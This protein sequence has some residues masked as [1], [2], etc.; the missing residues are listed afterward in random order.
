[1]HF[2]TALAAV[3]AGLLIVSGAAAQ[4]TPEAS[5]LQ[6]FA[7]DDNARL[8]GFSPNGE[9]VVGQ[10]EDFELCTY[11][12]PS[13]A[14]I[15]CADLE[16]Q[17][18]ELDRDSIAWAPDSSAFAFASPAFTY[19]IDSDLWR[20]DAETGDLTNLTDD[21]YDGVMPILETNGVDTRIDVDIAPA[22]SPDGEV[23]AFSRTVIEP[24]EEDT[25]SEVWTLD[26]ATGD[27]ARLA[28]FDDTEPGIVWNR[29]LWS[30]DG[31]TIYASIRHADSDNPENGIHAID[32]ASGETSQLAG[33][34]D[35]FDHD[36][37][38]VNGI[39]P[40]GATLVVNYPAFLNATAPEMQSGY[41]LLSVDDGTVEPV[42]PPSDV[43][44]DL[45]ATA[46]T[47]AFT[48]DGSTLIYPVRRL[49][50]PGGLIVA[51]DL[52][53]G[54]ETVLAA[55]PDSALPIILSP[56]YALVIGS[57]G[58][59]FVMTTQ[60]DAYLVPVPGASRESESGPGRFNVTLP[61]PEPTE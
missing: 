7:T 36:S 37:P 47:P 42:I 44:D 2:R 13:G 29:L 49:T 25:P 41:A 60:A 22:W 18:I 32:V 56:G 21:D 14:Q 57:N 59:A 43:T 26:L 11:A 3:G 15:A 58:T 48:P 53:T 39:S 28:T 34:S 10:T 35:E 45:P 46:M 1:M 19:L 54:D 52:A 24:D 20:F 50:T 51:R 61:S 6:P 5:N 55:L 12:V 9:L 31:D 27:A 23:I 33:A 4:S 17:H 30:P 16:S 38:M 8:L 40:D